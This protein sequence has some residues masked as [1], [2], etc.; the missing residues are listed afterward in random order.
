MQPPSESASPLRRSWQQ[1]HLSATAG[2]LSRHPP[3]QGRQAAAELEASRTGLHWEG[4]TGGAHPLVSSWYANQQSPQTRCTPRSAVPTAAGCVYHRRVAGRRGGTREEEE[5]TP[6]AQEPWRAQAPRPPWRPWRQPELSFP[7]HEACKGQSID[8][9]HSCSRLRNLTPRLGRPA[10]FARFELEHRQIQRS[11]LKL[12]VRLG[13]VIHHRSPR[14]LPPGRHQ[15]LQEWMTT[16]SAS[17][18]AAK[19]GGAAQVGAALAAAVVAEGPA[20]TAM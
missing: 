10:S 2:H 9:R 19:A 13:P 6:H 8:L 15:A 18:A 1:P 4:Q 5:G 14:W 11:D 3:T 12:P 16:K 17:E 20:T 7:L